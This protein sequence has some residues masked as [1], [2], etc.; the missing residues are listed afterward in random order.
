VTR[1]K[2]KKFKGLRQEKRKMFKGIW[3]HKIYQ[4]RISN[5]IRYKKF[6]LYLT[7]WFSSIWSGATNYK[8]AS[9]WWRNTT[10][11]MPEPSIFTSG[12]N[13]WI[14]HSHQ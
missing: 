10:K 9:Q 12:R 6:Q 1:K 3:Q 5:C 8:S 7:I 2:E 4:I 14:I 13:L 11:C